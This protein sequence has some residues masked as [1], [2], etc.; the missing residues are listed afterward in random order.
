MLN[1]KATVFL[2]FISVDSLICLVEKT[3]NFWS[4]NC[5][6]ILVALFVFLVTVFLL[7]SLVLCQICRRGENRS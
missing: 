5:Y 6:F 7:A 2:D 4:R 1:V 3:D